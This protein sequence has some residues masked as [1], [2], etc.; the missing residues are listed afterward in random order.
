MGRSSVSNKDDKI[1]KIFYAM[2]GT[3]GDGGLI[4]R[5]QKTG[6]KIDALHSRIDDYMKKFDDYILTRQQ[7]CPWKAKN[8]AMIKQLIGW[9]L[10]SAGMITIILKLFGVL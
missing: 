5:E 1:D 6:M 2:F 9:I 3:N 10:G 4:G 8:M 7:T